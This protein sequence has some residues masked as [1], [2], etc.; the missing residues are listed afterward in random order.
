MN[1]MQIFKNTEFG[2]VR[3][4][5]INGEPY[6]VGKD[7]A[8]ALGYAKERN[9]IAAHVDTE[10]KRD[11]PIQGDLGGT[12]E[13]TVINESGL[14]AL[15]LSSKLPSAKKFKRW[16]TSEVLPTIR[17]T[18][19]YQMPQTYS[20]ALRALADKAE[21]AERLGIENKQLTKDNKRMKPKEIFTDAV[22]ASKQSILVGQLAKILR[23]NGIED[24]GQNKLFDYLRW[25]GY[26]IKQRGQ[27]WN[28]PTQKS[29]DRGL[30]EIRESVHTNADGTT[31]VRHTPVVTPKGQMFFINGFLRED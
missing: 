10:D 30:F 31:V 11:A 26:L 12:Q 13:M 3:T 20:E 21:E 1:E 29:I 7:I 28:M 2:E 15:V 23:Q 5:E 14:Y 16:V 19:G 4:V 17:K 9:A 25:A 24:I 18:G 22:M 27:N 6:F 8:S